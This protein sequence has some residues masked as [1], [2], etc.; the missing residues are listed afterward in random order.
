MKIQFGLLSLMVVVALGCSGGG[1]SN[2]EESSNTGNNDNSNETVVE[3]EPE[4]PSPRLR[5]D[6]TNIAMLH[7]DVE[8]GGSEPETVARELID[9]D[10]YH[11]VGLS[12]VDK[13]KDFEKAFD[14]A[15][16]KTYDHFQS[17]SGKIANAPNRHLILLYDY[18]RL[19]MVSKT[20]VADVDG[21]PLTGGD[22][23]APLVAHFRD[24]TDDKEFMVVLV[25]FAENDLELQKK[26]AE[27]L[28]EWIRS[29]SQ[30]VVVLGNFN[31][32][33][34]I[35]N[36]SANEAFDAFTKGGVYKWVKPL[37]MMDAVWV[38][39]DGDGTNDQAGVLADFAFLAGRAKK[40]PATCRIVKRG[41]DFPD[42]ERTPNHRPVELI[43]N[44][45]Q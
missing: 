20:E 34:Q 36:E 12:T 44:T 1:D 31:F 3:N 30:P 42:D 28:R 17:K 9:I 39:E 16:P 10:K 26:Q 35:E 22:Y 45:K 43:V 8:A 29:A 6:G 37:E 21:K 18:T 41:R 25:Q 38:D 14:D 5:N 32:D 13:P 2:N 40:W 15:W 4:K 23:P 7:W 11:V 19:Y 24:N 27:G 33:Y